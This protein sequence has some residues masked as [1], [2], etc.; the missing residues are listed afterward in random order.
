MSHLQ[1][2][3]ISITTVHG[4]KKKIVNQFSVYIPGSFFNVFPF[5]VI[6]IGWLSDRNM[7][8]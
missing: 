2:A 8:E 5:K 6:L 4:P 7:S 3:R 1:L